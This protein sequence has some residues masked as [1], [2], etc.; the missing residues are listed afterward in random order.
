MF[1]Q[2]FNVEISKIFANLQLSQQASLKIEQI[3]RS[4]LRKVPVCNLKVRRS[5]AIR[6]WRPQPKAVSERLSKSYPSFNKLSTA[7][8][9]FLIL[10]KERK[11]LFH[12]SFL[13]FMWFEHFHSDILRFNFHF[14]R[15]HTLTSKNNP[16]V[17][18]GSQPSSI[19]VARNLNHLP[20]KGYKR[21]KR[22]FL[23]VFYSKTRLVWHPFKTV[24]LVS[25]ERAI[26]IPLLSNLVEHG[27]NRWSCRV[28]YFHL[29]FFLVNPICHPGVGA[30]TAGPKGC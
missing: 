21:R 13:P 26:T 15:F 20:K 4:L 14:S 16:H 17:Q 11:K 10:K 19:I 28:C 2:H 9:F 3:S 29:I 24:W 23:L 5:L 18:E 25:N 6:R 22:N 12:R 30:T 7:I 8:T 1:S 27:R